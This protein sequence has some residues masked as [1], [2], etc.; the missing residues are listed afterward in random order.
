[1]QTYLSDVLVLENELEDTRIRLANERDFYPKLC[2]KQFL[3]TEASKEESRK[4]EDADVEGKP[5]DGLTELVADPT[6]IYAFIRENQA[7]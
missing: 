7:S 6:T 5:S 2:F 1:M 3:V 4:I